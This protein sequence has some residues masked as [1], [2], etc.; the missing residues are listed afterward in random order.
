[1][2]Y[3]LPQTTIDLFRCFEESTDEWITQAGQQVQGVLS[4]TLAD[5]LKPLLHQS[6]WFCRLGETTSLSVP[7]GDDFTEEDLDY[8]PVKQ[9]YFYTCPE[10]LLKI[11]VDVSDVSIWSLDC[12]RLLANLADLLDVPDRE[13]VGLSAPLAGGHLWRIGNTR[14]ADGFYYPVWFCR[15]AQSQLTTLDATLRQLSNRDR[16]LILTAHQMFPSHYRLPPGFYS[17]PVARALFTHGSKTAI[18]RDRLYQAI[19]QPGHHQDDS[20][21]HYDRQRQTLIIA[22]KEPWCIQGDNQAAAIDYVYQRSQAGVWEVKVSDILLAVKIAT[23]K[24]DTWSVKRLPEL[25]KGNEWTVYL[26]S[27]RRGYYGFNLT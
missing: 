12:Q 15:G 1:M 27:T 14:L 22:G 24:P 8:D 21:V 26:T 19:V 4:L 9:R 3:L 6:G 13:R 20:P 18:N 5:S 25:F 2:N 16:G 17:L 23:H 10:T 11:A 7:C